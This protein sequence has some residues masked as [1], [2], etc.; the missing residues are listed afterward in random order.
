MTWQPDGP[1]SEATV[2]VGLVAALA[3][4]VGV[5]VA[6]GLGDTADGATCDLTA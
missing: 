4:A 3:I 1:V 5:E 6:I 2:A